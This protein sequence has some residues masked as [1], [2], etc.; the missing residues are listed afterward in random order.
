MYGWILCMR[1]I[2]SCMGLDAMYEMNYF[3]NRLII[4]IYEMNYFMYVWILCMRWII[5]W[6]M[7]GCYVCDELFN[8]W[9][10]TLCEMNYFM[11]E[12]DATYE[13]NYFKNRLIIIMKWII[14]CMGGYFVWNE[15]FHELLDVMYGMNYFMYGSPSDITMKYLYLYW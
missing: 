6:C 5:K 11:Y 8:V 9:L 12:L 1:W 10:D 14:S 15:L 3:M 2:I 7:V 13:M 4:S